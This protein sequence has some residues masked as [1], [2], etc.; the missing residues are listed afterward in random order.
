MINNNNIIVIIIIKI[1]LTLFLTT[2]THLSVV[3]LKFIIF[4]TQIEGLNIHFL[5]IKPNVDAKAKNLTVLPLLMIHGWPGSFVEFDQILPL[6]TSPHEGSNVVFEVICP[7]IPGY[8]FSQAASKQ[9]T[10]HFFKFKRNYIS[11]YL[12]LRFL[13]EICLVYFFYIY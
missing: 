10:T 9:G 13:N 7:S 2:I 4:R 1:L 6:L 8:A 11:I 5:H 3:V 12:I